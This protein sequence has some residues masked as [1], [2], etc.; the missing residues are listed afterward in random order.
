MSTQ[1]NFVDP[2]SLS[3][4]SSSAKRSSSPDPTPPHGPPRKRPRSGLS[5]EERKEARANRNRIAAQNSRDRRKAQFSYLERR[6]TELEE[7]NCRLRACLPGSSACSTP[8]IPE[9][10][11]A[12]RDQDLVPQRRMGD[13]QRERENRELR[14]RIRTLEKGYE[15][16]VRA[17]AAQGHALPACIPSTSTTA[18]VLTSSRPSSPTGDMSPTPSMSPGTSA[19]SLAPTFPLSPAPTHSSLGDSPPTF[20]SDSL[21]LSF[22]P[23]FTPV[24]SSSSSFEVLKD[25][26][27]PLSL[28]SSAPTCHLARVVTTAD[29]SAVALQRVGSVRPV[30]TRARASLCAAPVHSRFV[31]IFL[32]CWEWTVDTTDLFSQR[33]KQR[34]TPSLRVCSRRS[35]RRRQLILALY[36][37]LASRQKRRIA[38]RC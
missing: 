11:L 22:S 16:V 25:E 37:V 15:A 19:L 10:P 14:E 5:P 20:A 36:Q 18:S 3:L 28:T 17:F 24:L 1:L 12:A 9:P 31:L 38:R 8:S 6:V 13:D 33:M 21:H 29:L 32:S 35:S 27:L 2:S 26:P 34:P 23:L 30:R 7:E 4:P